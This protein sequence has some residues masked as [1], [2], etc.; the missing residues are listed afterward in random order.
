MKSKLLTILLLITLWLVGLTAIVFSAFI[1]LEV[2]TPQIETAKNIFH[3]SMII[4]LSVATLKLL[5]KN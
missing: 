3:F 1:A 5:K 2:G 4:L